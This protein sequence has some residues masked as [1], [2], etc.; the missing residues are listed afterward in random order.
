MA[1]DDESTHPELQL[2]MG[3]GTAYNF[4]VLERLLSNGIV[5]TFDL[6]AELAEKLG[7]RFNPTKF[8][9]ACGV[10]SDYCLTGGANVHEGTGLPQV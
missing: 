2:F 4:C 1:K 6:S 3:S 8:G 5:K 9:N 7:D 10:I